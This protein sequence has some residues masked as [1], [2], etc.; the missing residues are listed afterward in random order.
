MLRGLGEGIFGLVA[1]CH[2]EEQ[3]GLPSDPDV[4]AFRVVVDYVAESRFTCRSGV[5]VLVGSLQGHGC[6]SAASNALRALHSLRHV[7]L[8]KSWAYF[9]LMTCAFVSRF[10]DLC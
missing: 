7:S 9:L 8:P 5:W 4:V 10:H 3:A 1:N 2:E 6:W